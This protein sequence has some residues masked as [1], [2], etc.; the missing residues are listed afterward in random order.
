MFGLTSK[1]RRG[2]GQFWGFLKRTAKS[3]LSFHLPVNVVTR[4]L[5]RSLYVLHITIRELLIW[6]RR[7]FWLDP[8]FRSQCARVGARFQMEQLPYIVGH[9]RILIGSGVR[10]SGKPSI[11]F[12]NRS[13]DGEPALYIGDDTFIGHGC[14]F[15]IMR[16]VRIGNRCLLAGGTRIQDNDGHPLDAVERAAG[17][18]PPADSVATV[19]LGDDVWIGSGATILKGV[20]IGPRS[21][22]GARAV[23]TRDVP[24]DVI[25]AG[26]PARIVKELSPTADRALEYPLPASA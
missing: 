16:S 15:G 22:I 3:I 4:P 13:N 7:F 19:S 1:L 11:A 17:K 14:A 26:N 18:P 21:I 8:L 25:V 9:G 5:W 20:T 24:P 6:A 10:L 2:Q 23:V 12:S